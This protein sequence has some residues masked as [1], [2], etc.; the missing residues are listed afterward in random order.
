VAVAAPPAGR[1]CRR[2]RRA[3][4]SC[5]PARRGPAADDLELAPSA[6]AVVD[7]WDDDLRRLAEEAARRS[8]AAR[9]PLLPPVLSVTGLVDLERD[10]ARWPA[11]CCARCPGRRRR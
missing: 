11:R 7:R 2:P 4:A 8:P 1:P 6:Q 10:P 9:R 5:W 3:C